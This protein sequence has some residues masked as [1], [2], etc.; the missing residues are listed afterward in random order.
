MAVRV[1]STISR[2]AKRTLTGRQLPF[3]EEVSLVL[4]NLLRAKRSGEHWKCRAKAVQ[5]RPWPP[6]FIHFNNLRW[7]LI[8][9]RERPIPNCSVLVGEPLGPLSL[10]REL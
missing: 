4:P 9:F 3:C 6:S 8:V 5:L 10:A 7:S 1:T 2:P